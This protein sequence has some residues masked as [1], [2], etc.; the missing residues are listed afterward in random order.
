[1]I[2]NLSKILADR[3]NKDD[4]VNLINS[5]DKNF[6][7]LIKISLSDNQPE[8]WRAAWILNHSI[9]KNDQRIKP[10]IMK[11]IKAIK[12]KEDGHQRE[13]IRL[14]DKM[15]ISEDQ[16]GYLF[17]ICLTIWEDITKRPG[18]RI[19]AF[20]AIVKIVKNYP[21]LISEIDAFTQKHYYETLSSGIKRSFIRLR[22]ELN[23]MPSTNDG[24]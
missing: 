10:F 9:K 6:S 12:K 15:E 19:F 18:T 20:R 23:K 24:I 14:L 17:D 7:E 11:F 21:D 22:D 8:A 5:N 16:E 2:A 4:L 13:F 1:M 3:F